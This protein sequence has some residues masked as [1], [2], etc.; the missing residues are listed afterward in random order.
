VAAFISFEWLKLSKRMMPR[1]ILVLIVGLMLVAF[2][3]QSTRTGER[4]NLLLPRAWLSALSFSAF[5]APFFWP[6]LGGSWAGNEFGWGTIRAVLTRRPN[7][8]ENVLAALAVLIG[9]LVVAII[10]MLLA[11][12]VAGIAVSILT[13]NASFPAGVWSGS[14]ANILLMGVLTAWYVSAFYLLLA[15]AAA[16]VFRSAAVGIGIGI[17]GTLAQLVLREIFG[18]LGGVWNTISLH[19][20]VIYT[21]DMIT[22]V[23]GPQ[24][25]P[26]SRL[27]SA[28]PNSPSAGQSVIALAIYGAIFLAI[29]LVTVR[30]RDVTD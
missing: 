26:G 28:N 20:P 12:T 30:V 22:R 27:S 21:N 29:T 18:S 15:F 4:D 8:I 1:I 10:A 23:V 9:A 11:G 5:F 2:W 13:N 17:G 19:F 7:R 16:T 6:V 25:I 3:G 24:L 14:F